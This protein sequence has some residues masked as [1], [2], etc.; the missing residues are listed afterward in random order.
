M[1]RRIFFPYRHDVE[2][3]TAHERR[4]R[5][6]ASA[7]P[8]SDQENATVKERFFAPLNKALEAAVNVRKCETFS[9]LDFLTAGVRRVLSSSCESGRAWVQKLH[10]ILQ[11]CLTANCFFK[12][13]RSNRRLRLLSE[14][15]STVALQVDAT[16]DDDPFATHPELEDFEIYAG[17]GHYHGAS[18]HEQ[19]IADKKYAVQHFYAV[20][21]R[22]RSVHHLDV[23]RPK[24]GKKK[25]HDMSALKRFDRRIL[26]M[27]APVGKKVLWAYD[28]AGI[29]FEYW[30][31][32]K[33]GA[34]IY[35]LSREKENMELRIIGKYD[36]DRDDPR[37]AGVVDDQMIGNSSGTMLRRI[38]YRD[39]ASGTTYGF[40]TNEFTI[41][42]GILAFIYKERWNIEKVFDEVKNKLFEKK[43]WGK[44]DAAKCMQAKFITVTLNLMLIF[45]R[46]IEKEEGIVDEKVMKIRR[47]RLK[48]DLAKATKNGRTLSPMLSAPKRATQRSLQFIRWL[49]NEFAY[50]G[51]W[52][53]AM[54]ELRP[55]MA[56]YLR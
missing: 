47:E 56:E 51:S 19:R 17:D 27:G 2:M 38:V 42:P 33:Q 52:R 14:I 39:P 26:R 15:A 8:M 24:E 41:P 23:A 35:F 48:E 43:A 25:E 6:I 32:M 5:F 7:L 28:R 45:E 4:R 29:D 10:K 30:Y 21:Q 3:K 46:T 9:D 20:N 44:S 12:G 50:P 31:K 40:L 49:L 37:N 55:L 11:N 54:D 36:F 34:G 53:R 16:T 1:V 13:H 22:T 18:T